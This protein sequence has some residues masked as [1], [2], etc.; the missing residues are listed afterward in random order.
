MNRNLS[1]IFEND[2]IDFAKYTCENRAIPSI[3]DSFKPVQRFLYLASI[4]SV[5]NDWDKT[6]AVG[7]S[8]AKLGYSHGENSAQNALIGMAASHLNNVCLIESKGNFGNKLAPKDAAAPRY[9]QVKVA[10]ICDYL[11]KDNELCPEHPDKEI[12]TPIYYLPILPWVLTNGT[13]GMATGFAT[14]I[15]SHDPFSLIEIVKRLCKGQKID[16]VLKPKY[17]M[18][19]GTVRKGDGQ[20]IL[21]GTFKTLPF[22]KVEITELPYGY[23]SESYEAILDKLEEKGTINGYENNSRKDKFNFIIQFPRSKKYEDDQIIKILRLE[24]TDSWNITVISEKGKLKEYQTYEDLIQDWYNFRIQFVQQRIDNK[25]KELEKEIPFL[26]SLIRFTKDVINQKF[27]FR[28][29]K[30]DVE[31]K[32]V[33]IE[34]YKF[35]TEKANGIMSI[36]VRSFTEE[37]VKKLEKNL[38]SLEKELNYYKTTTK[39]KELL[40]DLD[41]LEKFLKKSS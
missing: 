34:R 29:Y 40:K 37:S 24:K 28:K 15:N 30:N 5:K 3:V 19:E 31:F 27:D 26:E 16:G 36:P 20:Y 2:W 12:K 38:E 32:N 39:E 33:L 23:S 1:N 8:V 21:T 41:E 18:F 9:T 17:P 4:K 35:E 13:E 6:A 25:I 10:K 7:S 22:N 14:E 11:F